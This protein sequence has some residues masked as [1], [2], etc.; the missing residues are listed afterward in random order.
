VSFWGWIGVVFFAWLMFA[1][2]KPKVIEVHHK[3]PPGDDPGGPDWT[4]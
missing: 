1:S 2:N 3:L 4:Q